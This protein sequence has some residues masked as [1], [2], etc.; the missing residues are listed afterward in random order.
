MTKIKLYRLQH[1]LKAKDV[2]KET[3]IHP[4]VLSAVELGRIQASD[5]VRLRL[6]EYYGVP[7]EELF[8]G[9]RYAK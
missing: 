2:A 6:A 4:T 8:T 3:S 7:E 1:D 9:R 5:N